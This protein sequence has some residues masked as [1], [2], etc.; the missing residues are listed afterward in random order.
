MALSRGSRYFTGKTIT[1]ANWVIENCL[2]YPGTKWGVASSTASELESVCFRGD[3]GILSQAFPW[4][5]KEYNINKHR[6]IFRN[7]SEVEGYSADSPDRIRGANLHGLWYDEA[8]SSRYPQFWY[9][10]ARPAVRMDPAKI[11][12]TTTPRPTKLLRDLTS[13]K[14]GRVHITTGTMFENTHLDEGTKEDLA[15]E[16]GGTRI[17]RQELYGELLDDFEGALFNRGDLDQYRIEDNQLPELTRIIVGVDPAMKAGDEH[18]ESGLIVAGE[19]TGPDG[20]QHAYIVEDRSMRGSP[21]QVMQTVA[22][23]F[24]KWAADCVVLETNQGG[25]YIKDALRTVDSSVPVRTVHATKGKVVRAEPVSTIAEQGRL[26]MVGSFP[27]L[28]DQLCLMIPGESSGEND[29]RSDAMIWAIY[30]LRHLS[31]GSY[32][33]AYGLRDCECGKILAKTD[34]KCS[35]CG[36]EYDA[37]PKPEPQKREPARMSWASAYMSYCDQGHSYPRKEQRCPTCYPSPEA[38]LATVGQFT[39]MSPKPGATRGLSSMWTRGYR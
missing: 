22:S 29:D 16:Y 9:A 38:I 8:A 31:S 3:S 15:R 20:E 21:Q 12:V 10:S 18:D 6:I 28:E 39:G 36:K 23:L 37:L 5:I 1:G 25:D 17:G 32:M 26:H 14:D 19:G 35:V 11:L 33:D 30:E 13:R 4:E 27:E 7:G 24:H 34:L 2:K